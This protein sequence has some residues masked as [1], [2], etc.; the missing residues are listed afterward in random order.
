[1]T[2]LAPSFDAVEAGVAPR[3]LQR[4]LPWA[5]G[6]ALALTAAEVAWGTLAV[7]GLTTDPS[8]GATWDTLSD[9]YETLGFAY[10]VVML[11][12][13][14]VNATW[15]MRAVANACDAEPAPE[16]ITPYGSVIWH[17]IPIAN[18][19]MPFRAMRETWNTSVR[20][21]GFLGHAAPRFMHAWWWAWVLT[22][23]L[24]VVASQL[25]MSFDTLKAG[26]TLDVCAAAAMIVSTVFYVRMLRAITA[27]QRDFPNPARIF[28]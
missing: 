25:S 7:A 18:L 22:S 10:L 27:A 14:G 20:G 1:M 11:I 23:L 8:D 17:A 24:T 16:R 21:P 12:A 13:Y 28:E 6:T 2:D 9:I 19:W 26:L 5:V 3:G 15:W 4:V